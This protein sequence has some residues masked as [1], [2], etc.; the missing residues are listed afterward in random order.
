[1]PWIYPSVL[2]GRSVRDRQANDVVAREEKIDGPGC[3]GTISMELYMLEIYS[4]DQPEPI[5]RRMLKAT[6]GRMV[7]L[8]EAK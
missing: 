5:T 6:P 1:M 3:S 4:Q 7:A 8:K 2:A